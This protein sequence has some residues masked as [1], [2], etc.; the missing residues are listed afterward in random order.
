MS[1]QGRSTVAIEGDEPDEVEE[2]AIDEPDEANEDEVEVEVEEKATLWLP[3]VQFAL[4]G[5][6]ALALVF[7]L[8]SMWR[9]S[10]H[11]E[12]GVEQAEARDAVLITASDYIEKM[13]ALDY[14]D[15]AG[16]LKKWEAI[17]TGTL[18]DQITNTSPE[19]RQLLADQQKVSVG[20]VVD[21]AVVDIDGDTATVIAA[22]EVTVQDDTKPDEE[23][24][25][26]RNRFAADLVK[27]GDK[28]LLETLDQVAVNLS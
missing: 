5:V 11:D 22:V 25:V 18:H 21:A 7:G 1:T 2:D 9:A 24:S 19:D 14:R 6:A 23:P 26:K 8:V 12:S 20:K 27:V 28:W 17:T 15:V 3:I 4:V 13:N 16:G 10:G